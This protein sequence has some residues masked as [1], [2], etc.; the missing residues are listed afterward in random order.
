MGGRHVTSNEVFKVMEMSTREKDIKDMEDDKEACKKLMEVKERSIKVL[1]CVGSQYK[2][3]KAAD[4]FNILCWHQ[5][6]P[7]EIG[8]KKANYEKKEEIFGIEPPAYFFKN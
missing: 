8:G 2:G 7:N 1:V 5:S 6:P 3:L 4:L